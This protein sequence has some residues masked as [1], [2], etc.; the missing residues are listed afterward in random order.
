MPG[1]DTIRTD[2]NCGHVCTGKSKELIVDEYTKTLTNA[3]V[4]SESRSVLADHNCDA[5]ISCV[6]E[7][8]HVKGSSGFVDC[9]TDTPAMNAAESHANMRV[10]ELW[11]QRV[12]EAA[13]ADA[14]STPFPVLEE[15]V[16]LASYNYFLHDLKC[17]GIGEVVLRQPKIDKAELL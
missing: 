12:C 7:H 5:P 11:M 13:R 4:E 6:V 17:Y 9:G 3:V 10:H 16:Q 1:A 8:T 14:I 2:K 15:L